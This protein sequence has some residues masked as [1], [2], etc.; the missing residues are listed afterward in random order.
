MRVSG[1]V[2]SVVA[3]V[4]IPNTVRPK[5]LHHEGGLFPEN[6]RLVSLE[7]FPSPQKAAVVEHIFRLGVECPV[8]AF[9]RVAGFPWN[10][11]E[12]V[13]EGQ[14][15]ANGVLP[16]REL[17]PVVREATADELADSA[18]SQLLL[19]ALEDGHGDEGDVGV[20]RLHQAVLGLALHGTGGALLSIPLGLS[21]AGALA[22][23]VAALLHLDLLHLISPVLHALALAVTVPLHPLVALPDH[24]DIHIVSCEHGLTGHVAGT[25]ASRQGHHRSLYCWSKPR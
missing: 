23:T 1:R 6:V 18:E 12:A 22:W 11:D 13:V 14:V 17:L 5:T 9:A 3:S 24:V 8:V 20:G 19:R 25:G 4:G 10:L 16:G 2:N 15:M 21:L 7:A